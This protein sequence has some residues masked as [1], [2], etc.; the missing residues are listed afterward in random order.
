MVTLET[1]FEKEDDFILT[2]LAIEINDYSY[3]S[4]KDI[5]Q[6]FLHIGRFQSLQKL[7][8]EIGYNN[9]MSVYSYRDL[10]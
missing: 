6:V 5:N 9:I 7:D 4:E 3:L 1:D 10:A 2:G 8:L